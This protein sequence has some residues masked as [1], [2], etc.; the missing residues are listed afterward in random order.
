MEDLGGKDA[1]E[2]GDSVRLSYDGNRAD[3]ITDSW[4]ELKDIRART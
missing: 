4:V 1:C 2:D 3:E